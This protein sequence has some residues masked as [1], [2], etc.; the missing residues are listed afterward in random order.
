MRKIKLLWYVLTFVPIILLII[1]Y[2]FPSAFFSNQDRIRD[3]IEP[4]GVFAPFVFIIIQILQVVLTP[5]SHYAVSFA[6]GFIFGTWQGFIYNWIGRV[7]GTGIAFFL[8]RKF[9]RKILKRLIK[10]ETLLKYDRIFEKGK[11]ILFIMYFLPFFPDDEL[12]Y[13]AGFSSMKTKMF[14]PIMILGHVGGSLALAYAG[15]GISLKDPLFIVLSLI[16]LIC[17]VLFVVFYRRVFKRDKNHTEIQPPIT[18]II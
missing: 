16:T 9:G 5:I 11:F 10:R 17:G 7:V 3:F 15:S 12:S 14:I 4:Y 6:G 2:I 8:G 18:R 13:L 1:G